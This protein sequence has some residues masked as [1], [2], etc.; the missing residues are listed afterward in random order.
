MA[1]A[2]NITELTLPQL[3]LLKGQLDQEVEFLSSSIAQ[4]KVV[5]T[6]ERTPRSADQ[7]HVRP[8]PTAGR[9]A[10]AHRRGDGL[11]RGE[12]GGRRQ[13]FLQEED[14]LPHQADGEDPA[15]APGE[16]H[17]EAGRHGDDEPED[18]AADGVGSHA[19]RR[20]QGLT[21]AARGRAGRRRGPG[22]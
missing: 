5:Q 3:E 15:R 19:G 12:V 8:G 6:K 21:P 22:G 2:V 20:C 16:A 7:L 1:Q 13:G 9:G 10:R 14:R 17:D 4:L 18:P 11:L